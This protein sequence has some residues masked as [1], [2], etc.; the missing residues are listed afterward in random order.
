MRLIFWWSIFASIFMSL[1][2]IIAI[3]KYKKM[4]SDENNLVDNSDMDQNFDDLMMLEINRRMAQ[5]KVF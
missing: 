2:W 4:K 3:K 5:N 1:A